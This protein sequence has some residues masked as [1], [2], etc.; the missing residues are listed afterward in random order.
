[1]NGEQNVYDLGEINLDKP[2]KADPVI[3]PR[4]EQI[5]HT[6]PEVRIPE[7][8]YIQPER[9]GFDWRG[10]LSLVVPGAGTWL[11]G[12]PAGGLFHLCSLAFIATLSWCLTYSM[13]RIVPTL[14][15]LGHRRELGFWVLGVLF[16][17]AAM[18]YLSSAWRAVGPVAGPNAVPRPHPFLAGVASFLIPGWGQLLNGDRFRSVLFL[19]GVWIVL[20]AWILSLRETGVL[21][22]EYRMFLPGIL[23]IYSGPAVRYTLPAVIW[24]LAVYDAVGRARGDRVSPRP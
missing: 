4:R 2:R 9:Q 5:S 19:A 3:P 20:G 24:T 6:F 15:L 8:P 16:A 14:E 23:S 10:S 18:L 7:N 17:A 22:D 1:M 13:D 11:R 12:D 21:L